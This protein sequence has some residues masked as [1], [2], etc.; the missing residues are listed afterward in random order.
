MLNVIT[1]SNDL[2][3]Y[4]PQWPNYYIDGTR[5]MA[6]TPA[7]YLDC[8]RAR[9]PALPLI[10]TARSNTN[11]NPARRQRQPWNDDNRF[12]RR[13]VTASHRNSRSAT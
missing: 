6:M 4:Y 12:Q 10:T 5:A 9:R 7:S 3:R 1:V 11:A 13:S 2:Q 8:V